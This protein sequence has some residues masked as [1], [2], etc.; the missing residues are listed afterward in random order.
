M[1]PPSKPNPT[2]LQYAFDD[3]T[4]SQVAQLLGKEDDTRKYQNRSRGFELVWN[5]ET[6]LFQQEKN[7]RDR[8]VRGIKGFMQVCHFPTDK[9]WATDSGPSSRGTRMERLVILT[10]D[11]VPCTILLIV[12]VFWMLSIRMGF[13]KEGQLL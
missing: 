5:S 8:V 4:I 6:R 9:L 1:Y 11:I 13:M 12:L 7:G 2:S 3:F 10:R